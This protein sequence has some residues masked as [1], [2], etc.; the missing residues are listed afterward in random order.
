[1][2]VYNGKRPDNP[3]DILVYWINERQRILKLK[4]AGATKPWSDDPIFQTTYFCN[5]RREDDKVTKWIRKNIVPLDFETMNRYNWAICISR[6][7]NWPD[8]LVLI[9]GDLMSGDVESMISSLRHIQERGYKVWGNA[10]VVTTH[11]IKVDKLTYLSRIAQQALDWWATAT[12]AP[13]LAGAHEQIKSLE[14]FSDFMAA[15]VI[16]DLKN[17]KG[18]PLAEAPDWWK[19][20]APGPGSLRGLEW[21]YGEKPPRGSFIAKVNHIRF[22]LK[23]RIP[24]Q[25][26]LQDLQNCLCEYDKY[27]RV[28][29]GTGKSKRK[30]DGC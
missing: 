19:W 10:Y 29:K 28:L 7:I 11:G 1:M 17:T 13:T 16:A 15:Q 3:Q 27:M 14:G 9:D 2:Y 20:A 22:M 24:L 5:V 12:L 21:Y 26:C 8:S 18:H 23:D 6:L 30:Y 25:L 4:E